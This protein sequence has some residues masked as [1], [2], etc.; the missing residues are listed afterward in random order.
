[1]D[2]D[3]QSS[4]LMTWRTKKTLHRNKSTNF[5]IQSTRKA[6]A[7]S[8]FTSRPSSVSYLTTAEGR[9]SQSASDPG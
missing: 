6:V 5:W 9:P 3:S 1:M 2:S 8:A 4:F 7:M